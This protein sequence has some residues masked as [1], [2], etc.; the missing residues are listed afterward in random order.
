MFF[1]TL[2]HSIDVCRDSS[3]DEKSCSGSSTDEFSVD[4]VE[5]EVPSDSEDEDVEKSSASSGDEEVNKLIFFHARY[6]IFNQ[7]NVHP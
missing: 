1:E 6:R 5:Y 2:S 3:D 7:F 4:I